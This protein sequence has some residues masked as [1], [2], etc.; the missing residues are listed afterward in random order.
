MCVGGG[1]GGV[2]VSRKLFI[3]VDMSVRYDLIIKLVVRTWK[4]FC[5]VF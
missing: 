2:G 5:F 4:V 1:G 3:A